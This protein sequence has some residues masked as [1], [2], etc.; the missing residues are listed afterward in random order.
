MAIY[1]VHQPP[2]RQGENSPDPEDFVFVRDGFYFWG[3]VF[4]PVW[5]AWRGLWLV[6]L[7]YLVGLSLLGVAMWLLRVN[8]ALQLFVSVLI[9]FLTGLEASS[10]QR[11]TLKRRG[12]KPVGVVVGDDLESAERR[13]FSTWTGQT[14]SAP[15]KQPPKMPLRMRDDSPEVL[16]LFPRPDSS[17]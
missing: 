1:T 11:W 15:T 12:Y 9:A 17:R 8:V 4:G 7:L 6:L 13:F 14:E 2:L 3:F 10:L 5:M 16:G